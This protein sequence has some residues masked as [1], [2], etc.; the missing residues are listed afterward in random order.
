MKEMRRMITD[1]NELESALM[2]METIYVKETR[3]NATLMILLILAA[4]FTGLILSIAVLH[5]LEVRTLE[6][7][8]RKVI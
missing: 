2:Q 5:C 8:L 3:E 6:H 7:I 4:N 1:K